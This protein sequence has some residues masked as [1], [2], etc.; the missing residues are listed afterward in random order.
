M[1]RYIVIDYGVLCNISIF[2]S[3][4]KHRNRNITWFNLLYNKCVTSNISRDFL[5]LIC[6]H[7]PNHNPLAKIFNRNNIKVSYCCTSN[8]S[9]IIKDHIKKIKSI[10]STIHSNKQCNCRDKETCSLLGNCLQKNVVYRDTV[11]S[12]SSVKQYISATEGTIKQR[13]HNLKLFFTNRNYLTNISLSTH[14]VPKRHLTH[15]H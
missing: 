6:K 4:I 8:R 11:K 10:H 5:N 7:F 3:Y 13:I 14:M 15:H 9:Q 1:K 12:N 2:I